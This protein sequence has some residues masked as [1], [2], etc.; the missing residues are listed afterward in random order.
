MEINKEQA[1]GYIKE[2]RLSLGAAR[3]IFENSQ[4]K[5]S[6]LW[7]QVVKT[8]YD[9]IE[10][11]ISS[12][13]AIKKQVIPKDHPAK[14]SKFLNLY[15]INKEIRDILFFWLKKRSSSQYVDIKNGKVVIPHEIFNKNHAEK[16]I[17]DSDTVIKFIEKTI[18][19]NK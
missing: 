6:K 7:A 11:A 2:A 8:G 18:D 15:N 4:D 3:T 10:Q 13:L 19:L 9:S 5:N 14:I 16:I 17:R 1:K 12:A